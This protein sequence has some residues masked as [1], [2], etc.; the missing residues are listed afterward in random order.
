MTTGPFDDLDD[1][2]ALPRVAGLAVAA[3]GSRV[4]TTV[5]EL[6]AAK[7]EYVTAVWELDPTGAS[8][9]RRLTRGAK[10]EA[11]PVFTA[12]G[13]LLFTSVRAG[14]D[15]DTPPAAL[16][17]L[18]A[19]GGEAAKLAE[20]PAGIS[21]VRTARAAS[22]IVIGASVLPSAGTVDDERRLRKLRKDNKISAILHTGYPVRH[23]DKDLGPGQIHLFGVAADGGLTDLTREP[24]P[25]L[26]EPDFAVSP[27]G[28]FAVTAWRVA[29]PRA[30]LR[31]VL[32]RIDLRTGV[33]SVIAEDPAA[34]LE[35]PAISP[36]GT[37][38]AFTRETVSTPQDAPRITLCHLNLSSGE[39]TE[40]A[41]G[42]DRWPAS[43]TW[44]H[45]GAALLV[46]ADD[47][48]RCPVFEIALDG[49]V[50]QVTVDDFSYTNVVAAPG[51]VIYALRTSYAAP[52]H[53]VR[54]DPSGTLTALPCVELPQ[55]PGDL[56][57]I[58][59]TTADGTAVRSWLVLPPITQSP[60]P[61]LLWI[62]G[63]PLGSWN[64]W[65]W[66]WNPWL[67]A[68]RGYAVLLPDPAL[69]TGY[70]Q[71]FI[72]RGWGAWGG[73]PYED[74]MA[75]VDAAVADPRIDAGRTAAMGGSFGGYM[76]NW[77]AGHT[78]RFAAI[79]THASLWALDQFGATTDGAYYWAREMTPAM[80]QANSP[81][82][83]VDQI[84]TP[85]LVIHGD[86]DYRVPIGEAL[87]LWYE[88]LTESGSPAAADGTSA[89]RF[90]YFPSENHW[91][92]SPQHAKIWYQVVTAFLAEHVL[93]EAGQLPETLG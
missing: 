30:A 84:T 62:H 88:L 53:P 74:L 86:K 45:D 73:P 29:A 51:G 54:I 76:A 59:A 66:R 92:L 17:L 85:M 69:S 60:A 36:D 77:V 22:T 20:L 48:G 23:W 25:A 6:N 78:D 14:E 72:Q 52:P 65:S 46:T 91:V 61:L 32:M 79:V 80:A 43:V 49:P 70:G 71:R 27:D 75:A 90:L 7:T 38:V 39:W 42:W 57:E 35:H 56:T 87:R 4:V 11:A 21:A 5:A 50:R 58:V 81:H 33:R 16:W 93:G 13:D 82:R 15:D 31:S 8:P 89:H 34:D 10:G 40:L 24:G 83:F 41:T 63:G 47:N 44:A 9:A 2:I 18:P 37:S 1:Y 3:D 19:A 64:V 26:G 12:D 67:M 68:A 55:L 28:T